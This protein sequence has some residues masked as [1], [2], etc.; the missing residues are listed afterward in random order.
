MSKRDLHPWTQADLEVATREV[1]SFFEESDCRTPECAADAMLR[2]LRHRALEPAQELPPNYGGGMRREDF[3]IGLEFIMSDARWRCTD[4]GSR[5]VTA[6][7]LDYPE[8]PRW[9]NGPT[10]AV[11][12]HV[13]DEDDMPACEPVIVADNPHSPHAGERRPC[14]ACGLDAALVYETRDKAV[15]YRGHTRDY[16]LTTWWCTRCG[17]GVLDA[18]MRVDEKWNL[19]QLQREVDARLV[20]GTNTPVTNTFERLESRLRELDVERVV[21]K[22][23]LVTLTTRKSEGGSHAHGEGATLADAVRELA[24]RLQPRR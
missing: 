4:V 7:K 21:I 13:I 12:E 17:D 23:G 5:V 15:E 20:G 18:D 24:D 6:I 10:Y 11:V 2:A 9:Y 1:R 14:S 8:D 22:N 16:P 19:D 3:R